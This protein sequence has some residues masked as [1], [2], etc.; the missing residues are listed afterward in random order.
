[1]CQVGCKTLL[2]SLM[3]IE[4]LLCVSSPKLIR[5]ISKK[6]VCAVLC[7]EICLIHKFGNLCGLLVVAWK[8]IGLTAIL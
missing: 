3:L 1:M 6:T 8:P 5:A 7:K 4:S 2:Y